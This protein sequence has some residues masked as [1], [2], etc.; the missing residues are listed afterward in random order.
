MP[1]VALHQLLGSTTVTRAISRIKTPMSRFQTHLGW[2]PGGFAESDQG[3]KTFGYDVFN[4]TR[5]IAKGRPPG[6]GP[7]TRAPQV[8]GHVTAAAYRA[9]EKVTL[10]EERIYRTRPIGGQWGTVDARGQRYVT[11]QEDYL[12]QLFRNN[13]EFQASRFYRGSF[14]VLIDG[15]DWIPVDTGGTFTVDNKQP[16]GNRAQLNMLGAGDIIGTTWSDTAN[17]TIFE[18]VMAVNAAY[19]QLHG[20][21]LRHAWMT[22]VGINNVFNNAGLQSLSGTANRV[23]TTFEPTGLQSPDGIEDTGFTVRFEALPWLTWHVYDGGLDVNGTFTKY[24][25]DTACA[26]SPEPSADWAEWYNGSEIVAENVMSPGRERFGMAGWST[27]VIDPAGFEIKSLDVGLGILYIPS[28]PVY[29]TV[30]F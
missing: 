12:A 21:P 13:R 28:V 10:L 29:A 26:M 20:R 3:G 7:A 2:N 14:Q 5:L 15:D 4:R 11:R 25:E 30:V 24:I 9:H 19:E 18:D 16:A 17:A 8:L 6:T 1:N 22:S 23:F 27:R